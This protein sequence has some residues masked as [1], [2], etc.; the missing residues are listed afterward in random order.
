MANPQLE[1][2]Y[3]QI[4]NEI[5][6]EYAT[7][8]FD[9]TLRQLYYQVVARYFIP[10][11]QRSY[12]RLGSIINDARLAGMIDWDH[13]V[14]RTRNVKKNSHWDSPA[15][16][17]NVCADQYRV[18]LWETQPYYVEVWIEKDAL[19]GVISGIC[20]RLD[21]PHFSCRGYTSQSEMW[22]AAQRLAAKYRAGKTP[23][24]IH[25]SD[26]D[27]SGIDMSGDIGRR[28]ELFRS[29]IEFQRLALT[30]EQVEEFNPPPNPA[31][32]TDSR[33][34][35]YIAEFGNESWELDALEPQQIV[36]YI[37]GSVEAVIDEDAWEESQERQDDEKAKL[38]RLADKWESVLETLE[39]E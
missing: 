17:I 5:L 1:D 18:D 8:G 26:H 3:T 34:K 29:D 11:T 28:M 15:D 20:K 9:L 6:E 33:A 38:Q 30:M 24:I 35:A 31:K 23:L 16:I 7:Q 10:N 13:I 32:I 27:P 25:L 14:D 4:A 22:R 2:G 19:I 21:V 36:D 12:Q 39:E 37:R